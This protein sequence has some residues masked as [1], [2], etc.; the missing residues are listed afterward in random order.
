MTLS[1]IFDAI[2]SHLDRALLAGAKGPIQSR[3][4]SVM[5]NDVA[6]FGVEQ[7]IGEM[8]GK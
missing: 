5:K 3:A 4:K 7:V 6:G 1:G 8:D 2:Q